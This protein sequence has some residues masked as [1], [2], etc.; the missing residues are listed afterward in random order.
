M[1]WSNLGHDVY[2][3]YAMSNS[4]WILFWTAVESGSYRLS[5]VTVIKCYHF[6][7]KLQAQVLNSLVATCTLK[8][9]QVLCLNEH[10]CC[11]SV[12]LC[13]YL[14]SSSGVLHRGDKRAVS[15][16]SCTLLCTWISWFLY[17]EYISSEFFKEFSRKYMI[18]RIW[19]IEF[20]LMP[21]LVCTIWPKYLF[22]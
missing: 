3:K 2:I 22:L 8:V 15:A 12:L 9:Y 10:Q 1:L 6:E 7:I 20:S 13:Q 14:D 4:M 18:Y 5:V 16:L 17:H 19:A 11:F 21:A